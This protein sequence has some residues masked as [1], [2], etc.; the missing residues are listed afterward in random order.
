MK[1][2]TR[3]IFLAV[4]LIAAMLGLSTATAGAQDPDA[5][6]IA[7][8][9]T[10]DG[11]FTTLLTGLQLTGLA[12][13]F[14]DCAG[15]PYTVLAPTDDAFTSSFEALGIDIAS[16]VGD[17]ELLA[18]VLTYHVVEGAV[19]STAVAGLDGGS[20]PTVQG[21]EIGVA[22]SGESIS[23][24]SGNPT[25]AN[26]IVADVPACN[27]IIHAID[28]VLVPPTVAEALGIAAAEEEEAAAE[29]EEAAAEE[30][31]VAEEDAAA[32]EELANTGLS[33]DALTVIAV[34]VLAAG[35][36][37][38]STSRRLSSIS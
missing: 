36:L 12:D 9:A 17:T 30:E 29:E 24:T 38:F 28:A 13:M 16:L 20:A 27:G 6:S 8:V 19:D 15:G 32:E 7:D 35:A 18:S 11:R 37:V 33:S 3:T 26:V 14:G 2:R 34:A 5:P 23:I 1:T 10:E 4:A 31:T 25:P 22:V 21:E